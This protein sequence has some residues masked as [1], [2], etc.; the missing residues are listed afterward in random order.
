MLSELIAVRSMKMMIHRTYSELIEI[1]T[2]V[3]RYRY[4][5]IKGKIG[6]DTFGH[7]RYL[8]QKLYHSYEWKK[9]REQIIMRDLGCDLAIED[10]P[11]HGT[12]Y[13]HHLNPITQKDI[14]LRQNVLDPENAICVSFTTHQ[15]IHY[16]DENLLDLGIVVRTPNDTTPWR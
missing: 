15:A 11:I 1:P 7:S 14:E 8:N 9:F 16:G 2:F 13:I 4:L 6:E 10:R 5:R 3:E 12:I